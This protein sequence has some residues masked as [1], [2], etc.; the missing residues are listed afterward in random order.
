[1]A[2]EITATDY[3]VSGSNTTPWHGLG[4][5]VAGNLNAFEAL[6]AA[7]LDWQVTQ[8]S[9]Y[10][11]D[12]KEVEGFRLNRRSDNSQVLGIVADTWSPIQN[13]RVLEIAEA[14][15][16]IDGTDFKPV[17]ETAGS[18]QGGKIVWALVK[19]GAR[20]FAGSEHHSFLLLSNGHDGK[21]ALK[22]TLTDTRVVCA[23]TLRMAETSASQLFVTHGKGVEARVKTAIQ[24]LGWANDATRSTFAV[25]EALTKATMPADKAAAFFGR[26][27]KDESE[28]MTSQAKGT[29]EEMMQLFRSG[30]G[31]EG[32]TAFDAVNA[33]TDW[34]DHKRQ[35]RK[36][37][38]GNLAER[39]FLYAG[40]GGD[41]DRMKVQAFRDAKKFATAL[42]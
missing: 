10:D 11:G 20:Q 41:G 18:L 1:M 36:V 37:D 19:V 15:A 24:T 29:V 25:F 42:S 38:A 35:F 8:E 9:I 7:R 32:R 30:Q 40:L 33:V 12:M 16:Q 27:L 4:A 39:R 22:G 14:L 23:N 3:M 28:E 34:V 13:D 21:R 31:N 6:K 2:H 17:I 5:V 26:L